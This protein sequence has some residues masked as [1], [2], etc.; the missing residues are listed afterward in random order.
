MITREQQAKLN[1]R[2][3]ILEDILELS[4]T[5]CLKL[6]DETKNQV[7]KNQIISFRHLVVDL[8]S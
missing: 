3:N 8:R 1:E 7:L 4:D 2:L 5:E 6:Y